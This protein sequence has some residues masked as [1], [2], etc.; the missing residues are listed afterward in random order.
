MTTTERILYD[1]LKTAIAA[2]NGS[3]SFTYDV[4]ATDR[5]RQDYYDPTQQ[6]TDLPIVVIE[7]P[8]VSGGPDGATL[9]T[10]RYQ[11]RFRLVMMVNASASDPMT[12]L[13]AALNA[14]Q[15]LHLALVDDRSLSNTALDL[16][17]GGLEAVAGGQ[18]QG[19]PPG[20]QGDVV[21]DY[22]KVGA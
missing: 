6:Q 1:N 15:D 18:R 5:V 7:P 10:L 20:V 13:Q 19:L 12:R 16:Y 9:T 17:A 2:I 21:V 11:A 3:G 22:L 14:L 4:S 8:R